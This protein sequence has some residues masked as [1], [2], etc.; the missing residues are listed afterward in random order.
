MSADEAL[1]F[2]RARGSAGGCGLAA[3]DFDRQQNQQ[4]V[5]IA[6]KDKATSVETLT[7]IGKVTALMDSLG[8]NLRTNFETAEVRTLISL[9][10]DI[11]TDKITSL[12]L[13]DQENQLI[14]ST[15]F[16][17]ISAQQP[18]LGLYEYGDIHAF[19]RKKLSND[20]IV[21]EE[22]NVALYN[23]TG[24][25]GYAGTQ[26]ERLTAKNFTITTVANAPAG[27]YD[28]VEIYDVSKGKNP[29]TSAKLASIYGITVQQADAPFYIAPETDFVVIFA[30]AKTTSA[31]Q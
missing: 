15:P 13:I 21:R 23:A 19:L 6:L 11:P 1:R 28:A 3:G 14:V 25:E 8:E 29:A 5:I 30:Q 16:A 22:A 2:S 26:S 24:V 18:A 31:Q 9:T 17:G 4:K 27:T 7:N 12:S 10:K 20:K